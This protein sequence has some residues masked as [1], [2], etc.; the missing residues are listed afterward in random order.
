MP[1]RSAANAVDSMPGDI[2][3]NA[4]PGWDAQP[5]ALCLRTDR[6]RNALTS[7][8]NQGF[9]ALHSTNCCNKLSIL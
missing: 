2:V 4:V 5:S 8:R 7:E 1:A 3:S 6:R 9:Y